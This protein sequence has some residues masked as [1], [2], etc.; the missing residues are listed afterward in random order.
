MSLQWWDSLFKLLWQGKEVTR[1]RQWI[2]EYTQWWLR[3]SQQ[4]AGRARQAKAGQGRD[5]QGRDRDRDQSLQASASAA[6]HEVS[7]GES[8]D[9][10]LPE[11][12]PALL[13]KVQLKLTQFG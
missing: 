1:G 3:E 9:S 5:R 13:S 4:Q 6:A 7:T 2:E 12:S 10:I 11:P 8:C